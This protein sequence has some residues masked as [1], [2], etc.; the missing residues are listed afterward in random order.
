MRLL[1]LG[2]SLVILACSPV[3]KISRQHSMTKECKESLSVFYNHVDRKGS[4]FLFYKDG[5]SMERE[6]LEK[7]FYPSLACWTSLTK[8]NI[9]K[10]FGKSS[11]EVT[12]RNVVTL[13]YYIEPNNGKSISSDSSTYCRQ[14][15]FL[16]FSFNQKTNQH[17]GS[18]F[19]YEPLGDI[20]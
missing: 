14:C 1:L 6:L 4:E 15:G 12:V 3:N 19:E 11:R 9:I 13:I 7:H 2:V 16:K 18:I 17:M 20:Y 10:I 8:S 5:T